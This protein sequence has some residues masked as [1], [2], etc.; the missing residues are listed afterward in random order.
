M[1]KNSNSAV[2]SHSQERKWLLDLGKGNIV[3]GVH[4][5]IQYSQG[6]PMGKN[7][8]SKGKDEAFKK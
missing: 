4:T 3:D 2:R 7:G 5:L 1:A 8:A 6:E